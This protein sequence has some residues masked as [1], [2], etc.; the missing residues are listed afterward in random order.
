MHIT[1]SPRRT[2]EAYLALRALEH[3][4]RGDPDYLKGVVGVSRPGQLYLLTVWRDCAG[5][6]RML[7]SPQVRKLTERFPGTWANEWLP[8][9]EFGHWDG[10]RLRRTRARYAIQ[11]PKAAMDLDRGAAVDEPQG[12]TMEPSQG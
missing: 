1:T 4:A 3:E 11:M 9:N 8:E 2:V 5:T 10:L 6:R 7:R 12:S